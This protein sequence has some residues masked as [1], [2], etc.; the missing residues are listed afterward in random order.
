MAPLYFERRNI[1]VKDSFLK[2]PPMGW[3]SYDYYDTV[4]TE[5]D[6]KANA[7]YMAKNL[8]KY[9]WEY[10]VVDIEWYSVNAGT[11]RDEYQY[12]PFDMVEI[13]SYSRLY[14]CLDRFPSSQGKAGFKPLAD[15]VHSLGLKFGIHIMRG[16]PRLAAHLHTAIKN[17]DVRANEVA[18]PS[19]ICFW[20]PDMYGVRPDRE[21][22]QIYYDSLFALYAQWGVDFVKCDDICRMD[23]PSAEEEIKMIS[24]A[25]EKCG[26]PIV[27]SLSPGPAK[28]EKAWVY[29]KYSNMW[30]ITDDFW[31]DWKLLLN[32]FDRC[33]LWQ[34]H[35][36]RGAYPDCDMLPVG[37]IGKGFGN[38]RNTRFTQDEQ[39]TMM[40]LWCI[41]GSPLMLG[42]ELTKLDDATLKLI[43]N[44][45]V[46]S[47][48]G[49]DV[50]PEQLE[51]DE[52][53]V[54]WAKDADDLYIAMF[55]IS[56]E[57]R[58]ISYELPYEDCKTAEELWSHS[59]VS[60]EN[61]VIQ[62]DIPM[63]GAKIFRIEKN[64]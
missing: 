10:V 2:S 60:I 59:N 18:D 34:K 53:H 29:E 55:N 12:I 31:D 63:H 23:M 30:R 24:K 41:F 20:N 28:I 33:E 19:S 26:R 32:M 40:S 48:L 14:P 62:A 52:R 35:V 3:N 45:D 5:E 46:L 8:K 57:S 56:D 50:Q 58:K 42:C 17:T 44:G 37:K 7:E 4:V 39:I 6:V 1:M 13:D 54:I 47:L 49:M 36:N 16:I 22:S 21:A 27:L 11:R 64:V 38:E 61:N 9:G 51:R 15:Y 25:I 43:T